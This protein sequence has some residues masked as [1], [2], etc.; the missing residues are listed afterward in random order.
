[1]APC[2]ESDTGEAKRFSYVAGLDGMIGKR[3]QNRG[4]L[5]QRESAPLWQNATEG[6]SEL[7]SA[8][9]LDGQQIQMLAARLQELLKG[10]DDQPSLL[11]E[12]DHM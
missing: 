4:G 5:L 9:R 1:M 11:L 10:F 8:F 3:R 6:R 2:S 7:T 12:S